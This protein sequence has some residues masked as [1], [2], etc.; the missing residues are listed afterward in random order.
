VFVFKLIAHLLKLFAVG[1]SKAGVQAQKLAALQLAFLLRLQIAIV[2][3]AALFS[4][5]QERDR[6]FDDYSF[7]FLVE[8]G[9]GS[10]TWI[11]IDL[12]QIG[13]ALAVEHDVEAED[14][15]AH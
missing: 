3:F 15:K 9:V 11:G 13:F 12:E 1:F 8:R 4:E 14:L 10:Q 2:H 5:T 7:D 6:V